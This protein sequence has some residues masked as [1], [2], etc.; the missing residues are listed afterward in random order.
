MRFLGCTIWLFSACASLVAC[1][2]PPTPAPQAPAVSTPTETQPAATVPASVAS[3]TTSVAPSASPAVAPPASVEVA[4]A[5]QDSASHGL[6]PVGL[7]LQ[8]PAGTAL[9]AQ[10]FP[11]ATIYLNLAG[12]PGGPLGFSFERVEKAPADVAAWKTLASKRF[13]GEAPFTEGSAAP[14]T[15]SGGA[16][17][18]YACV[19]GSSNARTAHLLAILAAP[20]GPGAILV[21]VRTAAGSGPAPSPADIAAAQPVAAVLAS[22]LVDFPVAPKE[23]IG[24]A[25]MDP[26]G[27]I[28]LQLRATGPGPAVGDA[29]LT[30][31]KSDARYQEI[32]AHLGG[33]KPGETKPVRPFPKKK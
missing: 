27:T 19:T 31:K 15:I 33:L 25:T 13:A 16:R 21:D 24:S 10:K 26:D 28:R 18:A 8:I 7:T 22:L 20:S 5:A 9:S 11:A 2:Q 1:S 23:S 32:L 4:I 14:I 17:S 3:A 29:V 30:Y 12:P 6:P